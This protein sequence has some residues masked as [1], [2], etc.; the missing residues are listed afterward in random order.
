MFIPTLFWYVRFVIEHSM[1]H[2]A[3]PSVEVS[4]PPLPIL[5]RNWCRSMRVRWG[6]AVAWPKGGCAAKRHGK[7][8]E[9][10]G[11]LEVEHFS[12]IAGKGGVVILCVDLTHAVHFCSACWFDDDVILQNW[13]FSWIISPWY[14]MF[15]LLRSYGIM[16]SC[17]GKQCKQCKLVQPSWWFASFRLWLSC[18][19]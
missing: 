16:G 13:Y 4:S 2:A 12:F 10:K 3:R 15:L 9:A 8:R 17:K 18:R 11:G 5:R 1:R 14:D 7:H 6:A 19:H